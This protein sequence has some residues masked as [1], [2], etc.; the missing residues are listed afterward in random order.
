MANIQSIT[1]NSLT[2]K[3]DVTLD[4]VTTA[5]QTFTLVISS[6]TKPL[7]WTCTNGVTISGAFQSIGD[8][9]V[10]ALRRNLTVPAG[11]SS[12]TFNNE[13]LPARYYIQIENVVANDIVEIGNTGNIQSVNYSNSVFTVTL[14]T[15]L[16]IDT[17]FEFEISS[18]PIG[19]SFYSTSGV[20]NL[21][22]G[23]RVSSGTTSFTITV[24]YPL[25]NLSRDIELTIGASTYTGTVAAS[26]AS[27]IQ[28]AY[29]PANTS[30]IPYDYSNHLNVLNSSMNDVANN[31]ALLVNIVSILSNSIQA[32]TN[33]VQEQANAVQEL[34]LSPGG[35]PIK[36]IYASL[37][38]SS[39]IKVFEEE[40][41]DVSALITKTQNTLQ[42][43][44]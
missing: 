38:Y 43:L 30:A 37:S 18:D 12:F 8:L 6:L 17:A 28:A 19:A 3:Y 10:P 35:I 39:L 25:I 33:A 13:V 7:Q 1:Y 11:I 2:S 23:I 21:G 14:S 15:P 32:Q 24:L 44:A 31:V 40:G 29:N 26:S 20:Y 36:D 34:L 5:P 42:G 9:V 41:V 27:P 22:S 4:T 16:A